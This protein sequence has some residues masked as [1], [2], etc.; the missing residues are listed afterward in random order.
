MNRRGVAQVIMMLGMLVSSAIAFYAFYRTTDDAG[1]NNMLDTWR[2]G[3]EIVDSMY[4]ILGSPA[5]ADS[6]DV[7]VGFSN[8]DFGIT[9]K[10]N[11]LLLVN[12]VSIMEDGEPKRYGSEYDGYYYVWHDDYV[13][14]IPLV[15]GGYGGGDLVLKRIE[16]Y[17]I[18][19]GKKKYVDSYTYPKNSE[20]HGLGYKRDGI[21]VEVSD[22]YI[23][24]G[25][26][27]PG[28]VRIEKPAR[29]KEND[30]TTIYPDT[31]KLSIVCGVGE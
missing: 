18:E 5:D 25:C 13:V 14:E 11:S 12:S 3:Y 23:M 22:Y 21:A 17:K 8:W 20:H 6:T 26:S 10:R 7:F 9:R 1:Q 15:Y 16:K 2:K 28:I 30:E 4:T 27:S 31:L 19:G 29:V 24:A